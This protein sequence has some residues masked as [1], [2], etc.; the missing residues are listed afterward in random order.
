MAKAA[1]TEWSALAKGLPAGWA[2][3]QGIK[4]G[5]ST[6]LSNVSDIDD[7]AE[8]LIIHSEADVV[9]EH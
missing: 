2:K 7:D 6:I 4:S 1:T 5:V 3:K 8:E 9:V